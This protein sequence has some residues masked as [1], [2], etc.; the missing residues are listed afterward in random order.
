[1]ATTKQISEI[2]YNEQGCFSF[3]FKLMHSTLI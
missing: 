2:Q 3:L 1:M